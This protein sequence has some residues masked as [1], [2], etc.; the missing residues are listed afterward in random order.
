MTTTGTYTFAPSAADLI[1]N[2]YGMIQIRRPELTSQHL[3]DAYMATNLLMVDFSNRN[4]NRWGLETQSQVLTASLATYTLS[5]RTISIAIAYIETTSGSIT[6]GRVLGP[7]SASEYAAIPNKATTARPTSYFFSLLDPPT[8]TLWPTPDAA[9]TYTLQMQTFRQMQDVDLRSGTT[10][11]SP[12]R[13]LD[14][15]STGLAARLAETYRP[16]KADRLLALY[17][18]RFQLA[19]AQDQ[20]NVAL[21]ITPGLSGYFR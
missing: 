9:A 14:A 10:V 11:D 19:A 8:I 6:T 2:A 15:F 20:E 17:E 7:I 3:E 16:E 13:F 21:F 12:Y 1:L 4:P 5:A 18:K